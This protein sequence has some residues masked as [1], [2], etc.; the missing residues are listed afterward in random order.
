MSRL[1][2]ISAVL[3]VGCA[4]PTI[5]G[6]VAQERVKQ[7]AFLLD[8]RS[9]AEFAEGHLP[10]AVNVPVQEL[11]ATMASLPADR[12]REIV[13]YCRS[14]LRSSKARGLLLKAGFAKVEDLGGMSNW[15]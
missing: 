8:V 4:H 1:V 5:T 3:L 6:A 15:K 13:V 2:V 10:G 14:G 7:G 12:S 11:E 9:P